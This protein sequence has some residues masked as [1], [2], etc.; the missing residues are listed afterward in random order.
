M[1]TPINQHQALIEPLV[2]WQRP[3]GV[4]FLIGAFVQDIGFTVAR[5]HDCRST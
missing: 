2:A 1:R 4:N 3:C 5:P